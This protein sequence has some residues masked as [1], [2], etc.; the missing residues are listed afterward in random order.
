MPDLQRKQGMS[1]ARRSPGG[2]RGVVFAGVF[3]QMDA[4]QPPP[5]SR[6]APRRSLGLKAESPKYPWQSCLP[7]SPRRPPAGTAAGAAGSR[8][9]AASLR[10]RGRA[11]FPSPAVYRH[12]AGSELVKRSKCD[13]F[14]EVAAMEP[15]KTI[16]SPAPRVLNMACCNAP[17]PCSTD[18]PWPPLLHCRFVVKGRSFLR[19]DPILFLQRQPKGRAHLCCPRAE[20]EERKKLGG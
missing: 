16:N 4:L 2:G 8:G 5:S 12:P 13:A 18:E 9:I 11:G 3:L 19:R 15:V 17:A 20:G 6:D 10:R 1:A 7:L 14:A